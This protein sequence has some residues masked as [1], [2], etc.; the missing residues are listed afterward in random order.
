MYS[1]AV[2]QQHRS[3]FVV[4]I[5]RSSSMQGEVCINGVM[6]TKGEA[7]VM[8]CNYLID[9]ILIRSVRGGEFR[10]YF[11]F[12]ILGYGNN[13]VTSLLT[14]TIGFVS[15]RYLVNNQPPT[16]DYH[17][18]C[19]DTDNTF[20]LTL[21]QWIKPEARGNTPMLS[22]LRHTLHLVQKWCSQAENRDSFPPMVINITDGEFTDNDEAELLDTATQIK[23]C[24][25]S[26]GA[27]LLINIHLSSQEGAAQVIFPTE[28]E[29]VATNSEEELLFAMASKLP[30]T[31]KS[32]IDEFKHCTTEGNYRCVA[33][34]ATA[35][36]ILS[37][38]D[39]GTESQCEASRI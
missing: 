39:I 22:A 35:V 5:D 2:T 9:E 27:T 28:Q 11:D 33:F 4:M 30:E 1:Q 12:A 19:R 23:C 24:A 6:M 13:Q 26:D 17:F 15:S 38:L 20:N 18:Q 31:F 3:A 16:A 25:T 29:F 21:H 37:I 10:D 8:I 34:N 32:A 36:E 7:V 14:P